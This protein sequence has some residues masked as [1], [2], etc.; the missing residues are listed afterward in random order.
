MKIVRDDYVAKFILGDVFGQTF[1]APFCGFVIQ[2][3]GFPVGAYIF[4]CYTGHDVEFTIAL[5]KAPSISIVRQIARDAFV[6]LG[7]SRITAKTRMSNAPARRALEAI[8]CKQEST[9]Y[10]HFGDE[11]AAV[12]ALLKRTQKLIRC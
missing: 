8:G 3:D 1:H 12:Y 2:D 5:S 10:D 4:N 6:G 11:D 9:A 7:V